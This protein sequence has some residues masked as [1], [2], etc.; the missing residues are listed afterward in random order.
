MSW[1]LAL[2]WAAAARVLQHHPLLRRVALHQA[3]GLLQQRV[4]SPEEVQGG[5][6]SELSPHQETPAA[7]KNPDLA[8]GSAERGGRKCSALIT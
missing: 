3:P 4:L 6:A 5:H 7:W 1:P 2:A 8:E